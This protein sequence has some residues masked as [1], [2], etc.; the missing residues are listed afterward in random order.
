MSASNPS[1]PRL[2]H[3]V[4]LMFE[5]RS[6]DNL[7]GYLY[8]RAENPKFEGVVSG[9]L[10]NQVVPSTQV[11]GP[12]PVP[13]HPSD[14]FS[15][16]YPDPGEEFPH[17]NTQLYGIVDPASNAV[18]T[19]DEMRAP[20]NSPQ[21]LEEA[22]PSMSGFVR[23]YIAAFTVQ[24]GRQPVSLEYSQIMACY[25]PSQ[26]PVL[27]TLARGFACFDHWFCE[28]PSQTYANRSFFHAAT[29]SGY[30]NNG[31][32]PGKFALNNS[33]P[34][35]FNQLEAA[36]RSW[37]VYIDPRQI[38]PATGLIH[39]RQLDRYFATHFRTTFDFY[40]E[41]R[42]GTLPEYAFIEPNMFHPHTDMH[43]HSGAKAAEELHLPLPDTLIGG[44][45]L[46]AQV[47]AAIRGAP[48]T[49]RSNWRNTCLL[50]T[51]DEHGGTF[52]HVPPPSAL[53]PNSGE[54][55]EGFKF[56]RLGV[57]IPTL[58]VSAWAPPGVVVSDSFQSTSVIRTLRDWWGLGAPLTA[59]DA[60]A[61]NFLSVLSLKVPRPPIDWPSVSPRTMGLVERVEDAALAKI[62]ALHS[63]ME[64]LERDLLGDAL[65]HEARVTGKAVRGDSERATH[66][67]AH[68]HFRRIRDSMF[69]AIANGRQV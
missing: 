66:R 34:T 53:P 24:M 15:S 37:C 22:S 32:P 9:S 46:L 57:R 69:T 48:A 18:A 63:P 65:A 3:V 13:V 35:L 40:F 36:G 6:F 38:L 30:V 43:P 45:R 8:E 5:N 54:G 59:R 14:T 25:T 1:D 29:S 26:V 31:H 60:N 47:Y 27:S 50:V 51:F 10:S 61:P 67:E 4:V 33:G 62:E 58:L 42:Q 11:G 39:A 16:P 21:E 68:E 56:N 20:F 41:A 12:A 64:R 19:I 49:G 55:E 44:E 17:V 28:V 52:D 23:D 7:L 2:D